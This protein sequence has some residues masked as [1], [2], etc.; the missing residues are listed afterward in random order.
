[1]S[2]KIITVT[3]KP[4]YL[5]GKNIDTDQIIPKV[6]LKTVRI[7]GFETQVFAYQREECRAKGIKHPFDDPT[8]LGANI[9]VTDTNFAC[10]SSREHAVWALQNWGI[11]AVVSCVESG[12]PGFADI[13]RG[14]AVANGMPCV[15]LS[16]TDHEKLVE[17]IQKNPDA[18]TTVDLESQLVIVTD[19]STGDTLY[20][21]SF[22]MHEDHRRSLIEGTWDTI[23]VLLEAGELIEKTAARLPYLNHDL[24]ASTA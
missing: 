18:K 13:F 23:S 9:L 4:M 22:S 15:E 5:P 8:N 11:Q 10:G 20:S 6:Y 3:G 2:A 14:N 12:S 16:Q 1:M 21:K 24:L 7:D 19:K 17:T